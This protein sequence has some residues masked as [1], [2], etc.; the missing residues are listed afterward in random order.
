MKYSVRSL[1]RDS[2]NRQECVICGKEFTGYGNNPWPAA[3]YGRCCDDCNF[4]VVLPARLK[5]VKETNAE[6]KP[7]K[8]SIDDLDALIKSEEEAIELYTRSISDAGDGLEK[9]IYEEILKDEKEHLEKLNLLKK[10][11]TESS[12]IQ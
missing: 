8:D 2:K 7:V 4:S 12:K 1:M 6:T 11:Y 9:G 10:G 3:K 5:G